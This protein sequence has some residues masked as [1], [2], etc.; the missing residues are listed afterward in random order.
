MESLFAGTKRMIWLIILVLVLSALVGFTFWGSMPGDNNV[1]TH[2]L[3]EP[4]NG[5]ATAKVDIDAGDGNVVIDSLTGAE[6][7]LIG[8]TLEYLETQGL[9]ARDLVSFNGQATLTLK[10]GASGQQ[11]LRL[12]W[13][14][15]NGATNWQIHLNPEVSSDITA[16]S[17]GGNVRLSLAGLAIT[18]LSADTGG[19]NMD[20]V[21]PDKASDLNVT[22]KT[23]AGNV[24]VDIGSDT[25]GSGS[26][27]AGSGAGNVV[28]RIP[29]G[30]AARI[31]ATTGLGKAT[32]DPRFNKIGDNT[33]ES[34]DYESATDRIEIT[35]DSGAGDVIV[36]TK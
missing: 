22:V 32:I 13:A 36:N 12:P 26:I 6:P 2:D 10:A 20:V 19:G 28:V 25:T 15:C 35:L 4:L 33:Y 8:G 18:Q 14:A 27:D 24:T 3:S 23:G 16:H 31:H 17:N 21:L 34:P 5:A 29:S 7:L 1:L 30:I 11:W 9:P